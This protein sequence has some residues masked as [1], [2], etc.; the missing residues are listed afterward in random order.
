[1]T[2]EVTQTQNKSSLPVLLGI[3]I[4]VAAVVGVGWM[5]LG[6]DSGAPI[7]AGLETPEP[8]V[9]D[10]EETDAVTVDIDSYL[11]KARL[12][13][14]AGMLAFPETQSALYY[15][16]RILAADPNHEIANA[17]LDA[18]VGQIAITVGEHLTAEE[19]D[20]AYQLSLS[21]AEHRPDHSIVVDT[22]QTLNA[23]E[24]TYVEQ[25]L[26][27]A[28][29]GEN[30]A[31][32]NAL[33]AAEAL[34]GRNADYYVAV[35]D[36]LAEIRRSF[37]AERDRRNE[38][39]RIARRQATLTWTEKVRTAISLGQLVS[40]GGQ[41]ARDFL[42]E[43]DADDPLRVELHQELVE[44]LLA[45]VE[46]H[47]SQG[48]FDKAQSLLTATEEL[49][50]SDEQINALRAA[51]E[52]SIIEAEQA[53]VLQMNELVQVKLTRP[54]YP[55]RA[56][57]RGLEGWV[58]IDFTVNVA[59]ETTNISVIRSEPVEVFDASAIKA[60]EQWTFEPRVFRGQLITQRAKA[61]LVFALE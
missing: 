21:I 50:D 36:S 4:A 34:P 15:Y 45:T 3:T 33:A 49:S 46:E 22:Q 60:V 35:R 17:E 24:G 53:R 59:G 26:D 42:E 51:I 48:Q 32:D 54:R 14:D 27:H 41:S 30:S 18:V 52:G 61:R 28:R 31:A 13:A 37:N 6:S 23:L 43:R 8:A 29:A 2:E 12:A 55:R 56:E 38:S 11:R 40:P 16:G 44:A 20:D 5:T 9:L 10:V 7:E 1:M 57:K 19:F 58:E 47:R 39:A 25:A